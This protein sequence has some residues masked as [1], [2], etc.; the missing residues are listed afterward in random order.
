MQPYYSDDRLTVYH[1]DCRDVSVVADAVITDPP[2]GQTSLAWDRWVEGWLTLAG[3]RVLW[4]FGTLRL[5]LRYSAQFTDA[6]WKLS[7][8]LVWEKHNGSSVHAD[9]F[10]RVHENIA[11]FYRGAWG[12]VYNDPQV[13]LDALP[14]TVR[15]KTRPAHM[16]HIENGTFTSVDGGPRLMRSV[17]QVR[18]MHGSAQHPT[19][20]PLGVLTPLV[21]Y[22][23]PLDGIVYDPFC[24]S[25]SGL[26]AA[27]QSGRRAIGVE[28]NEQYCEMAVLRCLN[29]PAVELSYVSA[30]EGVH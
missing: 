11:Q 9:R 6:G 14:K 27:L 13:T 26:E 17:L 30:V 16:G 2:Y 18:S 15:R 4:T 10:R 24:G 19:E 23:C 22:S 3:H 7:Q 1:G 29:L 8:D 28:I 21:K 5:F 20:K 25:G 12:D